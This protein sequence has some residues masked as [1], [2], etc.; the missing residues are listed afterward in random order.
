MAIRKVFALVALLFIFPEAYCQ[1]S[2]NLAIDSAY[3][4]IESLLGS[5]P[6]SCAEEINK[7]INKCERISYPAG[8]GKGHYLLGKK[9][10]VDDFNYPKAFEHLYKAKRIFEKYQ[11][12]DHIA[13]CDLQIGLIY[14]LQRNFA[15]ASQYL[16]TATATF[17]ASGDTMRWR[18]TAYM[19]TLCAS[20]EGKFN[21]AAKSLAIVRRF[22][23]LG[24]DKMPLKEY[25]YAAGVYYSR[26][27]KS[28]SAIHYLENVIRLTEPDENSALQLFHSE[29][30]QAYYDR[31]NLPAAQLHAEKVI[32]LRKINTITQST[33]LLHSHFL[34]YN[35]LSAKNEHKN[36]GDHLISY[37][38]LKDSM[39]SERKSFELAS[40]KS[41]YELTKAEQEAKL[42]IARQTALQEQQTQ[43]QRNLKNLFIAGCIT[44]V[45]LLGFLYY[46]STLRKKKN[47]ELAESLQ[48]LK[49]TQEQLIRQEKLASM[50]KLSAGIAHEIKNPLNFIN[51][52]SEFAEELIH[53]LKNTT[54]KEEQHELLME[55]HNTVEKIRQHGMRADEIVNNMLDH[56]RSALPIKSKTNINKLCDLNIQTSL[57]SFQVQYPD[58]HCHINKQFDPALPELDIVGGDIGR[59]LLNLCNNALFAMEEKRQRSDGNYQPTLS[60]RTTFNLSEVEIYIRDN[61][62]GI[63]SNVKEHIFEPFFTTKGPGQGT[64][65]GL[66]ICN[67]IIKLHGGDILVKSEEGVFTEFC[68]RLPA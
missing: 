18:R 23:D 3:N 65:L 19:F 7:L 5:N 27:G 42:E 34:L 32:A 22:K 9:V 50:G 64:G 6:D 38:M 40:I 43:R 49:A 44:F 17:L 48:K 45:C 35:I 29:L 61:G 54:D 66:S 39:M 31:K 37:V 14:Y 55:M 2:A 36:A 30:A 63:P 21:E 58:I 60:V 59:V 68:V 16:K 56:S 20:E 62:S 4:Q 24:P 52:F 28:D 8:V 51:N 11:L 33:A 26:Q 57:N 46:T 67:E 25:N 53:D 1:V 41:K 13:R 47:A 12:H 10:I 15:E